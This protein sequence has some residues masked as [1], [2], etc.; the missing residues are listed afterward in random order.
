MILGLCQR[1][2]LIMLDGLTKEYSIASYLIA[3]RIIHLGRKSGWLFVS[4]YLKQ[5]SATLMSF[6][7]SKFPVSREL[8]VPVRLTLSGIPHIIPSYHRRMILRRDKKSDEVIRFFLY[9]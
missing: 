2:Q 1:V 7:G 3:K 9:I 6:R 5:C 4:L 8:S